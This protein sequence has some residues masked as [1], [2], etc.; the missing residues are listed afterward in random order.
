MIVDMISNYKRSQ[1]ITELFIRE[2]KLNI[3]TDFV[4]HF[5]FDVQKY[6]RIN[7]TYFFI[8]NVTNKLE[9]QQIAFNHS[10]D[11]TDFKNFIHFYKICTTKQY[12]FFINNTILVSYNPFP[13]RSIF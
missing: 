11:I 5:Y 8:M 12:Y 2:G 3:S 7:S 9:L 13:S 10:L 1:I 6:I 4:T